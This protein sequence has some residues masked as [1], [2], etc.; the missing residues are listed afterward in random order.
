MFKFGMR[1]DTIQ[2]WLLVLTGIG[3]LSGFAGW[4]DA[5]YAKSAEVTPQIR[6][7]RWEVHQVYT[8]VLTDQERQVLEQNKDANQPQ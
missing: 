2:F 6:E 7:L 1:S 3:L 5:R 8:K 4:A